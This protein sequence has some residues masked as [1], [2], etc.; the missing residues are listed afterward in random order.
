MLL[1]IGMS[2]GRPFYHEFAWAYDLLQTD[3]VAPRID[4]VERVLSNQGIGADSTILDA[5]C[6]T[7]RYALELAR[8][9]YRV[10]AVDRSPELIAVAQA[11]AFHAAVRPEFIV[12][13]LVTAAFTRKFDT[14][15]CRGVLND[16]VEESDRIAIFRQFAAWLR[17]GGVAIFDVR[18]WARTVARYERNSV[19][20]R[21]VELPDGTLCFQSETALDSGTRQMR[22]RECFKVSRNNMET[23]KVNEFVMKCWTPEEIERRLLTAG[24]DVAGT[25]GSYGESERTWSD[26]L[27]VTAR[28]RPA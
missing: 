3:P 6:G 7:G 21:T 1:E 9:G 14:V 10:W 17:P 16:L 22:I 18:E 23:S 28:K 8:R 19:H 4:F 15:L 5:G 11:R 12:G 13:D 27:V 24:F 2:G 25:Y 26:R 20:R